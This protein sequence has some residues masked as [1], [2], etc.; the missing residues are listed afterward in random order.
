M[1]E[2]AAQRVLNATIPDPLQ[3]RI[4]AGADE[5]LSG[6]KA[7]LKARI[8]SQLPR[9]GHA[10]HAVPGRHAQR[11]QRHQATTAGLMMA[12]DFQDLTGRS[13]AR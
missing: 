3:E 1:T 13:S 10:D 5:V 7:A 6:W 2:Q 9:H 4:D 11:H 12:Q 8:R